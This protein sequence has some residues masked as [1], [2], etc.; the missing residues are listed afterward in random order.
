LGF[1]QYPSVTPMPENYAAQA[2]RSSKS[3]R[4]SA[5]SAR[6]NV[7]AS[8]RWAQSSRSDGKRTG[9]PVNFSGPRTIVFM[10]G[11]MGYTELASARDVM[12]AES[13]EIIVGSTAFLSADEFVEDLG[14]L[15]E[16][17]R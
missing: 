5:A 13:R 10:V 7:G 3:S 14:R 1:D 16:Q 15:S 8:S 9:G 4:G 6:K 17:Q 12:E 2:G 11:G